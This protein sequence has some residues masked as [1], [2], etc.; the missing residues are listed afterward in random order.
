MWCFSLFLVTSMFETSA[1]LSFI[2]G[3]VIFLTHLS[4]VK[5]ATATVWTGPF[6]IEGVFGCLF[7][8]YHVSYNFFV[9]TANSVEWSARLLWRLIWVYSVCLCPVYGYQGINGLNHDA[10][11][12]TSFW[13]CIVFVLQRKQG[14]EFYVN[15]SLQMYEPQRQKAYFRT[16]APRKHLDQPA[17]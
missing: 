12:Q 8:Y 9:F 11:L 10:R 17:Q 2:F 14:L 15:L 13:K 1:L 16:C 5:C 3:V 7:C 4:R 6:P